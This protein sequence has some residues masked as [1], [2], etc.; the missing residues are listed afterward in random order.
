MTE[1]TL[2]IQ[3]VDNRPDFPAMERETLAWWEREGIVE[4]YL[5]RNDQS[6]Q[7]YSFL[8]GPIT[9]NNP[10][11]V[12]HAW[13]RTYKDLFQRYQTMLGKRQRYQNGFD[14]QGLW[15]E[16]EVEKELG[17]KS[18]R[19]IEAYGIADFV[20]RCKQRVL[21]FADR[22]TQ[23]SIRLGY[24]M[25]WDD[26]YYTMSDENNY[27]IWHF[28]KTVHDRG[29]LYKGHDVMP[30]CPRCGTGISEHEIVTE[31]YQE[32]T[33]LSVF[34]AFP[35]LDEEGA[36]LLVWT[37]TP[38]TLA[39]NVAAA[40]HPELVYVRAEQNGKVY[41][42]AKETARSALR[43]DFSVLGEVTGADLIGRP[44]AGPFDELPAQEGIAHRVIGWEDVGATEGTG[45]VHIAPGAGKEDFALSKVNDLPVIAPIDEF[46]VYVDGFGFLTGQYVHEVAV[47]ITRNLE[48][49]GI[50][51]RGEQY[52]H[53][54][55]VCWRCGTDLVFRLVDEWF[56]SM[57]ELR[58]PMMDVTRQIRWYPAF[59][60]D[61]ELD[62]LA[63]MD[64]WMISKKRYWGLA[65]PIYE[66]TACG[67]VD[68]IGS[69]T[70]L[71]ERAVAGWDAFAGHTPHRPWI[72]EVKIAC[73]ACGETV[74]RIKDVGNPWLDAG[75]VAFSTL[76][77]RHD[78]AYW[79][80]WFPADLIS[81]SFP[82][83]F[84]NWFYSLIAQST[85][86]VDRPAFRNVF[87]YALMR[88]EKGEEM[89]KSKGNAI[90]FDDAAEE[91]GVDVMR[92]LFSRAN[93]DS[94]LNFGPHITDDIRR[95]FI[96][97]LWNSYAFFATYAALD[98]F[99]P[100]APANAVPLAERPTLDRWIISQL[101]RLIV[102]VRAALDDYDPDRA[103]RAIERFTI[104]ELS[105]WYIRRNRRRFWKSENDV[106]KAAAYQTLYESLT[107]LARLLAPFIPFVAE[108]IY[109]NL[110]RSVDASAPESV[111]LTDYPA[112]DATSIDESLSRDM[113]AVLE[114]VGAGHAARQEAGVKVRQPLPALLVHTR[115]PEMLASVLRLQEQILEE[116]NVKAVEPMLDP[117]EFV[118]FSIRPNLRILGPRL[119]KQLNAVR[120]G[121]ATLDPAA[122]AAH[123]EA[124]EPVEAP[125]PEGPVMLAPGDILVNPV[126]LPGYAAAQGA[127]STVVLDT[128]L[129]PSLIQ[130]GFARD[131]VRGVQDARKRAGYRIEDT[132]EIGFVAD[133]EVGAAI[134]AFAEYVM[135]E[136]LATRLEGEE[137]AATSD[138]VEPL[139][140][141]GPG[142]AVTSDGRYIDQID[143]GDHQVRIA[144]RPR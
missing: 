39:A 7:R 25:D 117:G 84:R 103:A 44:Y 1:T 20:E 32:R 61:R 63:H 8:D 30:W 125:T 15:V 54:Y 33:H 62:W 78:P 46:G 73:S 52:R 17:L 37:T 57:D 36:N 65:L 119:G 91:I 110:V 133:P 58:G 22:I 34:V 142:G 139:S 48:E 19:D 105:N 28:L 49:K 87:S 60:L 66:C 94:N 86:L 85:A 31:G 98:R 121:L 112:A 138:A 72:D 116:L 5:H 130:E 95:Q 24:W 38:W 124:G 3:G 74:S 97:P 51:Y 11:G 127:R 45:I 35:L 67:N 29:W 70:E 23:Q 141:E 106:D 83:Q 50:L 68:V 16:V 82:G 113:D 81:E 43:G 111:H 12:H 115:E 99:D 140:V 132:I 123:V 4:K 14:C 69:E 129:T 76:H 59:G 120:A 122:V 128:S 88:D 41:Y 96:L 71:Q 93:P 75:I 53:R 42:L 126:R 40:V 102:E 13:G 107:T 144:L 21:R 134:D 18:K 118:T 136:T 101:H 9:A 64:D 77:Y 137:L 47:A 26:S 27:T 56:I 79:A 2:G 104:D 6:S 55:P 135:T 131:F 90:W 108:A 80:E 89:H 109:Q 114:V 100:M 143:V 92:W 10:M